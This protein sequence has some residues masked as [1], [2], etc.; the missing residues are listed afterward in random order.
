MFKERN[1]IITW[2]KITVVIGKFMNEFEKRKDFQNVWTTVQIYKFLEKRINY[3]YW[4]CRRRLDSNTFVQRKNALFFFFFFVKNVR[5]NYTNSSVPD[6][7][8]I[9]Y[10]VTWTWW[11]YVE[12]VI[13][14]YE[15]WLPWSCK[16]KSVRWKSII[17][18]ILWVYVK[19]FDNIF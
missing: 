18:L 7:Y 15:N 19:N 16:V 5:W 8:K 6:I 12:M 9:Y 3:G 13:M 2:F 1:D 4:S 11:L 10:E 17:T 14:I